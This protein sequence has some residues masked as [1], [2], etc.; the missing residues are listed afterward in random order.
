MTSL[1]I[2]IKSKINHSKKILV[3]MDAEKFE[4]LASNLGFFSPEFLESIEQAE[5]D[6]RAGRIKKIKSLMELRK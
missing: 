3:E 6:Y 1:T 2:T 5:K 4:R